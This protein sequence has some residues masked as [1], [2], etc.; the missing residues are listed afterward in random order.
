MSPFGERAESAVVM[1]KK[2]R[3]MTRK[4]EAPVHSHFDIKEADDFSETRL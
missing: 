3:A 1:K 4:T 2:I